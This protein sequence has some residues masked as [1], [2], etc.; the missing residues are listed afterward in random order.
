MSGDAWADV[1]EF[2]VERYQV[3]GVPPVHPGADQFRCL[4]KV[5]RFADYSAAKQFGERLCAFLA[6]DNRAAAGAG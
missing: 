3:A 1:A 2:T 6:D 4:V 5:S